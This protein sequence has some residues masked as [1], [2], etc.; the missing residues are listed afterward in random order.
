MVL[1]GAYGGA[2]VEPSASTCE[3]TLIFR[4]VYICGLGICLP[5][6]VL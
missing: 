5:I 6:R 1:I 4:L 3:V 2:G